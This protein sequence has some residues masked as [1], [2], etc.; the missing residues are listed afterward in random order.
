[1]K[2]KG[3]FNV[4]LTKAQAKKLS[5]CSSFK[6]SVAQKGYKTYTITTPSANNLRENRTILKVG[7]RADF[8]SGRNYPSTGAKLSAQ[9]KKR[10]RLSM[11]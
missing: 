7:Q 3:N 4:K 9:P 5:Q 8:F 11:K 6:Y 1:M 2:T 10:K